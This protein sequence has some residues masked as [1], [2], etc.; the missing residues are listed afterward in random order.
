M[1][2]AG[3]SIGRRS[4]PGQAYVIT[5]VTHHRQPIFLDYRLG[6]LVV[7]EMR[8]LHAAGDATTMAWVLMP[9]HLHW[10]FQ[11]GEGQTLGN[12]LRQVK[13]R[14]AHRIR[15]QIGG[16]GP[17]WQRAYHDH[18]LRRD[19][20]A[21]TVARYVLANPLRAGLVDSLAEYPLW[22]AIWL[23]GHCGDADLAG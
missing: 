2:Y 9:D 20:D 3:L 21:R 15:H 22:D 14:S 8:K 6:R 19:E 17:V 1:S 13:A 18:A 12:V 16:S 10:L 11:L 23:Q 4:I 7:M 5:T